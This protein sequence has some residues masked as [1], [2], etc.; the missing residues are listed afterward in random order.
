MR[1]AAI[2]VS[3]T[4][5]SAGCG[6]RPVGLVSGKVTL[7]GQPLANATVNFQPSGSALNAG[8]GSYGRTDAKGEYTLNLIDGSGSGAI[9]GPH[10]VMIRAISDAKTA[11]GKDPEKA[12]PDRVPPQYNLQTTLTFEVKSGNNVADWGLHTRAKP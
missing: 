11:P 2:L 8:V 3:L 7:D 4:L 5:L 6:G 12:S 10:R 1:S 9:I